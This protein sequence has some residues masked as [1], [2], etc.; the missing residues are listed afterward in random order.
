VPK[1]VSAA[2]PANVAVTLQT[3]PRPQ[4][5]AVAKKRKLVTAKQRKAAVRILRRN[6]G[7]HLDFVLVF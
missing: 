1:A 7:R 5:A 4:V 2:R 6:K 3:W